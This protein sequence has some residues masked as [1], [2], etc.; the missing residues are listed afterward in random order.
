M[1]EDR[2]TA[3]S[4]TQ[5]GGLS[6]MLRMTFDCTQRRAMASWSPRMLDRVV[7]LLSDAVAGSGVRVSCRQH[8]RGHERLG[9]TPRLRR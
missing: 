2:G 4:L 8:W 1:V 5:A 9:K 7:V 6:I 3:Y